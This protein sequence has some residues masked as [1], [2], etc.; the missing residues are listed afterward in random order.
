MAGLFNTLAPD[1]FGEVVKSEIQLHAS[2]RA[3]ESCFYYC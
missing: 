3:G 1:Y 2:D